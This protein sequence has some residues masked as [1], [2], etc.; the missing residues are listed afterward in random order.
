M[1]RCS[2]LRSGSKVVACAGRY[3]RYRRMGSCGTV[4]VG[5]PLVW[6]FLFLRPL[7]P[8][9][10]SL[11][12]SQRSPLYHAFVR[13]SALSPGGHKVLIPVMEQWDPDM[14]IMSSQ[15]QDSMI[16]KVEEWCEFIFTS[17]KLS[18]IVTP[19]P[20]QCAEFAI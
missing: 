19:D 17:L 12:S 8:S 5:L 14:I 2:V 15:A 1:D 20:A 10:P 18:C 11:M 7:F 3:E 9:L 4:Y 16:D 6:H 13:R